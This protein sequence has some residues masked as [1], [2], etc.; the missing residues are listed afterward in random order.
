MHES[1]S[2]PP[3]PRFFNRRSS[4]PVLPA[5]ITLD[6]EGDSIDLLSGSESA[7]SPSRSCRPPPVKK[8]RTTATTSPDVY[9]EAIDALGESSDNLGA[10]TKCLS[11]HLSSVGMRDLISAMQGVSDLDPGVK[12]IPHGAARL[13]DRM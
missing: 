4:D 3:K 7:T 5:T 13:L 2:R 1:P 6:G 10:L 9:T 11:D 12:S 8:A